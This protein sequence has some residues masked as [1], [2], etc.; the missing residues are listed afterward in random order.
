MKQFFYLG[1][2]FFKTRFL[3]KRIPLQTVLFISDRCNLRCKHCSVVS[4]NPLSKTYSQI[5]EELEFSY[6]LGSRFVDFEGGEVMLWRDGDKTINDL[7]DLAKNIG[8]FS[9]TITT[10]AQLPFTENHADSIWVSLDGLGKYHDEI[11]GEGA[12]KKLEENIRTA[13]HKHLSVNMVIN[14]LNYTSLE[15]TLEY[16]K[17]SPYIES[18]S[19]NFHTPF[20]GTEYLTLDKSIRKEVIEKIIDYK[21]RGY[22]IMNTKSGLRKMVDNNF[23]KYCWITNFIY[24][25]G[26]RANCVNENTEACKD[27]GFCMAGEMS[28]MFSFSLDTIFAGLKLRV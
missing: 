17:N 18:I 4:D 24:P 20:P 8:F 15:E 2:W 21:K 1:W 28:A 5:K 6:K 22:P 26:V 25:N 14:S 10:N 12:F 16:A 9:S 11:R 7:I 13:D 27:C 23:K 19:F 3:G